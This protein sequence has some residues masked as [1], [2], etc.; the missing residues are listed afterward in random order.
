M[1]RHLINDIGLRYQLR[2]V[3]SGT[4]RAW[5]TSCWWSFPKQ[6]VKQI[7]SICCNCRPEIHEL[8]PSDI[9]FTVDGENS[10]H[11]VPC[12]E[13]NDGNGC[14]WCWMTR[15][16]HLAVLLSYMPMV[17]CRGAKF[18]NY[19]TFFVVSENGGT[20]KSSSFWWKCQV[21]KRF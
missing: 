8:L 14:R 10:F 3:L 17:G 1:H 9:W 15:Q 16:V 2:T 7:T 11:T 6:S 20:R 4:H 21:G 13:D 18:S 19:C 12:R 5:N